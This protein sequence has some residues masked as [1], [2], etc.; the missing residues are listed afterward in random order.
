VR[1]LCV[2]WNETDRLDAV[3]LEGDL[4][5]D[6]EQTAIEEVESLFR[7]T[8]EAAARLNLLLAGCDTRGLDTHRGKEDRSDE[9]GRSMEHLLG[10]VDDLI[11]GEKLAWTRKGRTVTI[12]LQAMDRKQRVGL[13]QRGDLYLFRSAVLRSGDLPSGRD[14]HDLIYRA[15][16]RNTVTEFVAFTID[17]TD[18][19]VGVIEQPVSTLDPAELRMYLEALAVECDRFEY[20]LSG[21]DEG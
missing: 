4:L 17:E 14:L 9:G 1:W 5:F 2:R 21:T 19:L 6:P 16:R 11:A 13:A 20:A 3:S 8:T 18:S 10:R 15:W 7:R 12:R